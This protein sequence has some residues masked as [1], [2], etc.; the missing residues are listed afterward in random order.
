MQEKLLAQFVAA[1]KSTTLVEMEATYLSSDDCDIGSGQLNL[2]QSHQ[3]LTEIQNRL[4]A[5]ALDL[6]SELSVKSHK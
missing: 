5:K 1:S 2:E 6:C 4:L 3:R